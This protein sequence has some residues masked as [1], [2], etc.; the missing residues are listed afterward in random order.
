[1]IPAST[2]NTSTTI[3]PL[4]PPDELVTT[5]STAQVTRTPQSATTVCSL[6]GAVATGF[7][8]AAARARRSR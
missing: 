1:V 3:V 4:C 5:C 8:I 2:K 7:V 6:A